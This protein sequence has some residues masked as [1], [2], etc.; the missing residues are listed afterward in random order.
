[1]AATEPGGVV[2]YSDSVEV[3]IDGDAHVTVA[4]FGA[5]ALPDGLPQYDASRTPRALTN[6]IYID[7]DGDGLFSAPGGRE[8]VYSLAAP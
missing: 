4:A 3:A 5:N 6:P 8:C 2:K 1:M 7:G